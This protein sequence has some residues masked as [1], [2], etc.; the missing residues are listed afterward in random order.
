MNGDA[1]LVDTGDYIHM[2]Q[3]GSELMQA[4]NLV[5]VFRVCINNQLP[6]TVTLH[7]LY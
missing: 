4:L 1:V 6:N 7:R 2:L 3:N 5:S